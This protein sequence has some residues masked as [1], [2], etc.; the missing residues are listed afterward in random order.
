[1]PTPLQYILGLR[2]VKRPLVWAGIALAYVA[3]LYALLYVGLRPVADFW[4]STI[5]KNAPEPLDEELPVTVTAFRPT[6]EV[7]PQTVRAVVVFSVRPGVYQ[8]PSYG[9]FPT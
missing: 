4:V 5:F 2:W 1:M 8:G 3:V 7:R 6:Q 9:M